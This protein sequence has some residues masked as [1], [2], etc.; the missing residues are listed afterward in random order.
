LINVVL[1]KILILILKFSNITELLNNGNGHLYQSFADSLQATTNDTGGG[2]GGDGGTDLPN[3]SST[4]TLVN[5]RR[6][7]ISSPQTNSVKY[8]KYHMIRYAWNDVKKSFEKI[9]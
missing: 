2:G 6:N 1:L 5:S 8:F 4:Q 9:Q 3:Y 7:S